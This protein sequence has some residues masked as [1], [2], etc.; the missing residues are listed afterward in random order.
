MKSN[1]NWNKE[2]VVALFH[3]MIQ[4]WS[5]RNREIFRFK[6]YIMSD[7][8]SVISFIKAQYKTIL[9]LARTSFWGNEKK[10]TC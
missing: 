7:F 5:Q 2:S 4:F 9:S 1:L 8:N 6:M 3:M 10:N